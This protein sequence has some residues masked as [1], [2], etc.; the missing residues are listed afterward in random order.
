MQ[1]NSSVPRAV[2]SGTPRPRLAWRPLL[3]SGLLATSLIACQ[4]NKQ[5]DPYGDVWGTGSDPYG[6][7]YNPYPSD[8]GTAGPG[9]YPATSGYQPPSQPAYTPP[10]Q[11]SYSPPPQPPATSRSHTVARGDTLWNISQRY[12]TTVNAI[13]SA[14]GLSSDLIVIGQTLRIP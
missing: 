1:T 8:P 11:P 2:S 3:V 12:G 10:P 6:G 4:T 5:D 14:N 9:G 7:G 13:K